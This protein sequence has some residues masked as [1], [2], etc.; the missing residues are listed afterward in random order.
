MSVRIES[1]RG[2]WVADIIVM[3]PAGRIRERRE[4]PREITSRSGAER[5]ADARARHLALNGPDKEVDE[6][7]IFADFAA[8]WLKEYARAEGLK[9]STVDTYER[10]IRVHL[11]PALPGL[12]L[13]EI[14]EP[15]IQRVK[16]AIEAQSP[17]SRHSILGTLQNILGA[18]GRWGALIEAAPEIEKPTIPEG[19]VEFFTF[20]EWE[21]LLVGAISMGPEPYAAI[22]SGGEAGL[23]RGEII[24]ADDT[25]I[26]AGAI[27]IR[28]NEWRGHI[29]TTKGGKS[30]RVPLT[31]RLAA[32][33]Q[34]NKHQRKGRLFRKPNGRPLRI[35]TLQSWLET[36]CR[37]AGLPETRNIHKLRH[38]FGS[39]LAMR[40]APVKVI[41]ELM[42]HADLKTTMIYMHLAPGTKEAAIALLDRGAGVEP[43]SPQP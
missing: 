27:N 10:H 3:G 20:E 28:R 15:A 33:L 1:R 14:D 31:R 13:D 17:K 22:L 37:R 25:D 12:R 18:A 16:L 21:Q 30:R 32:A 4:V 19:K 11:V 43:N 35:A 40:N 7:P 6:A 42:G 29:G 39:H 9:P 38:T 8:R 2:H 24:A 5:W 41:Q 23:R 36:A 34:A 26:F